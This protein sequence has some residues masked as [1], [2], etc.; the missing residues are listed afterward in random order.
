[1][2]AKRPFKNV[3]TVIGYLSRYTHRIAISNYRI[4]RV[5]DDRV[6]FRFRDYRDA[7]RQKVMSLPAVEFM[8]RFLLHVLPFRFVKI[9]YVGFL[10][11]RIREESI[12][13]CRELLEVKPEDIPQR[14]EYADFA[15][16]L[17]GVFGFD[18]KRCPECNGRLV[19]KRDF[20]MQQYIRAP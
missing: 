2:Y 17:L 20:G 11:N 12:R 4:L 13:I 7:N 19:F 8:R 10:S 15:E 18:V 14:Q 16:F 3:S 9:R 6:Y 5:E 1:M